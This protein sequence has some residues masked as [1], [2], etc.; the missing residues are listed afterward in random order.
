M[1][2]DGLPI[3]KRA[4]RTKQRS[5][6]KEVGQSPI[7]AKS[8]MGEPKEP[9]YGKRLTRSFRKWVEQLMQGS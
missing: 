4:Q 5:A 6:Q 9:G 1:A 7:G 2:A 8:G 3:G